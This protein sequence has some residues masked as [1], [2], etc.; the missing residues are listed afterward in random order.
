M[1]RSIIGTT[2]VVHRNI[3]V[4]GGRSVIFW[5]VMS[6]YEKCY[7]VGFDWNINPENYTNDLSNSLIPSAYN[8]LGENG[9]QEQYNAVIHASKVSK[10]SV[11]GN[12]G[13]YLEW[14]AK[15]SDLNITKSFR[16]S[17]KL[18]WSSIQQLSR[19]L[20]RNN[21]CVVGYTFTIYMVFFSINSQTTSP[22]NWNWRKMNGY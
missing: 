3:Y 13:E 5:S 8:L 10:H 14:P 21:R 15:S 6:S 12:E 18:K 7:L 2:F 17:C 11:E 22:S 1:A 9:N 19:F 20:R 4:Q 16:T